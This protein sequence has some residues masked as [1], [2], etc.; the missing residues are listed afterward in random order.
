MQ[1]ELQERSEQQ[2]KPYAI[3]RIKRKRHEE[4]LDGLLVD[5]ETVSRRKRSRG[6]LNFFKFAATV[7]QDAWDDEKQQKDLEARL[8]DLA[9]ETAQNSVLATSVSAPAIVEQTTQP[10]PPPS[11]PHA[12]VDDPSRRYVVLKREVPASEPPAARRAHNA[13]PKIWST[14]ELEAL[15]KLTGFTMYD[16]V[17]SSST[18]STS[19]STSSEMDP[20]VAKFLPLLRDYLRLDDSGMVT[21]PGSMPVLPPSGSAQPTMD[22]SDYVYDVFYQ[23]PTTFQELYEPSISMGNIGT[24]L[25]IPDELNLDDS[26]SDSEVYDTDDEDSNAEDWYKNDYPDEEDPSDFSDGSEG[27]DVFHEHS[28]SDDIVNNDP[29]EDHEW[30]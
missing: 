28:D 15:R 21:P 3:L 26:D 18:L 4:P 30:R 1:T 10:A 14:K 13:P 19:T 5:P 20:E 8:A 9:R 23:R 7:E 2:E 6:A 17:P 16:A 22:D 27:S 12:K 11:T 29:S 25:D 24:L